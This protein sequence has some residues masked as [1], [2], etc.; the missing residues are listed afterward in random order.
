MSRQRPVHIGLSARITH[1]EPSGVGLKSKTLQV[2]EQSVAQWAASRHA[3]VL[4]VPSVLQD[5]ALER[6]SIRVGDYADYLDGLILQGGADVCPR[7]Y[8]EEPLRPEWGGDPVRDAYELELVHAFMAAGKPVLGICRGLQLINVA[9]GGSLVQDLPSL[10]P[11]PV[12][13]ETTAYERNAH[14][15]RFVPGG[16]MAQLHWVSLGLLLLAMALSAWASRA[17]IS[18]RRPPGKHPAKD[19]SPASRGR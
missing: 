13:H 10:R 2:L 11:G 15:V 5:G 1:P 7:T 3:L 12:Q 16:Q 6:S 19:C 8:G 14:N 18:G 4:M 9:L 17:A